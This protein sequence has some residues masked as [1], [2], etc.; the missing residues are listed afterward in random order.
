MASDTKAPNVTA[1]H[2]SDSKR[3]DNAVERTDTANEVAIEH[4]EALSPSS[5]LP[6]WKSLNHVDGDTALALFD[7]IEQLN[8]VLDPAEEKRLIRKVDML[9]LPCLIVCYTF[10]YVGFTT[11]IPIAYVAKPRL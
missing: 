5:T 8:E 6:A 9:I 10:Y 3:A 4:S 2:D 7:N 1:R 11:S